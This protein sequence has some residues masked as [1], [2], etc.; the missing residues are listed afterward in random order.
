MNATHIAEVENLEA[1]IKDKS[2]RISKLE[3]RLETEVQEKRQ[4]VKS[5][6]GVVKDVNIDSQSNSVSNNFN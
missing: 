5:V 2:E 4:L 6:M 3:K 1:I